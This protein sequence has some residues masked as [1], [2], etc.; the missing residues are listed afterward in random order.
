VIDGRLAACPL[1]RELLDQLGPYCRRFHLENHRRIGGGYVP[2]TAG[3]FV[4]QLSRA[5][6]GVTCEAMYPVPLQPC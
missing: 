4:V 3:D 5:P 2:V 6:A 1:A